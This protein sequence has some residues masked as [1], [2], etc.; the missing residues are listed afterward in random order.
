MSVA[1]QFNI[2]AFDDEGLFAVQSNF[3]ALF[4]TSSSLQLPNTA[5]IGD[6]PY[7]SAAETLSMLADVATGNALISG[8]VGVAPSYGKIGL[9][10]HVSG[11]LP[12][13][14]GGTGT[15]TAFTAGSVVFAGPSGIYAQD[16]ANFFWDDTNNRFG[17]G[18]N[19]SLV[20]TLDIRGVT[21][22]IGIRHDASAD[23]SALRFYEGTTHT[24]IVQHVGSTYIDAVRRDDLELVT[25]RATSDIVFRLNDVEQ[26][27]FAVGGAITLVTPLV[28]TSGGTGL[29]TLAQGDL[30][31]GS[32]TNVFSKLAK[33][34]TATRY[35]SNTGTA[36]NP[37]WAQV[38]L[39]NGVTGNLSVA[40][41]NSG[42]SAGATTF[43]RGDATWAVPAS[44]AH[45]VLDGSVH[46]DSVA[47]AVSR[48]SLIYGNATPKWDE[49][50][51]GVANRLLRSDG[52]DVSWAQ[53]VLTTDVT[54]ILPVA[55][56][57]TGTSTEL[58]IRKTADKP[59]T[60]STVPEAD[61][62]LTVTLDASSAYEFEITGFWTTAGATAGIKVQL[63][64]TVGVSSLKADVILFDYT[65]NAMSALDRITA[66]NAAVGSGLTG[67]NSFMI[68]GTI[69]TSTSGTFFLEWA[70]NAADLVNATTLQA[71]SSLIL[72]KLNA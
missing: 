59:I 67:D 69:V 3:E 37:A 71:N 39:A 47:Q 65:T 13:A 35:V 36:N 27:R 50:V 5:T 60:N 62:H 11:T 16:N 15:A 1:K 70:Q 14:N 18:A 33:D 49:L 32:A 42:T 25:L 28:M 45:V 29:A 44:T 22:D 31:F 7:A 24:A 48:G 26:A 2:E 38:N 61:N 23:Y 46:S 21:P 41:L 66:F 9:T 40:N 19:T 6:I 17:I 68:R 64:G 56:G 54:G 8:G 43:W 58:R 4:R 12:V 72:E 20:T 63:D 53:A 55:N 34:A 57:G 51:I 10:P 52:T 30:I